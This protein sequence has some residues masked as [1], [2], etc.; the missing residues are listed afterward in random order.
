MGI[1]TWQRRWQGTSL[2]DLDRVRERGHKDNQ[3]GQ[4][5]EARYRTCRDRLGVTDTPVCKQFHGQRLWP[6]YTIQFQPSYFYQEL[7]DSR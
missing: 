3:S 5:H 4:G 7:P 1:N 6:P 2:K